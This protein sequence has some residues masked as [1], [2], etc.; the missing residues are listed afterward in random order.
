MICYIKP[1]LSEY[2]DTTPLLPTETYDD[3]QSSDT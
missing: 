3:I 1:A 2:E